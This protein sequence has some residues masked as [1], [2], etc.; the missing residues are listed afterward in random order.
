M[1]IDVHQMDLT[2]DLLGAKLYSP[3]LVGPVSGAGRFHP[4]GE[5]AMLQGAAAAQAAVVIGS[6][7]GTPIEKLAAE[8]KAPLWYQVYL[9]DDIK[10]VIAVAQKAV[11]SGCRAVCLTVGT[12]KAPSSAKPSW[13]AVDQLRQSVK[14]PLAIKGVMTPQEAR[15][16]V[17]HGAAAVIVSGQS[18]RYVPGLVSPIEALAPVVDAVA[19][20]VPVL[21][22]GGFR[23]GTDVMAALALGA[24]AVLVA[25]P[26]LWGLAAYGAEGVETVLKMLQSE[27]ARDMALCGKRDLKSLD[28]SMLRI[29]RY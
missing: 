1:L 14:A 17:E 7:S 27:T 21:V 19:A 16:A 15:T 28:R 4:E 25:R 3:V 26:V 11:A 20:K 8:A 18:S 9:E 24:R 12:P 13:T 2:V 5:R 10:P 29:D 22:D 6:R 23:R